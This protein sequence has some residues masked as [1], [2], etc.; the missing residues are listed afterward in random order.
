MRIALIQTQHNKLYNF[1][2][3]NQRLMYTE[4]KKLQ[5][6][7]IEQ[8]LTL[9]ETAIN[10]GCDLIVTTEAINYAGQPH[11]LIKDRN[12]CGKDTEEFD[13]YKQYSLLIPTVEDK[14]VL[15]IAD[16]ARKGKCYIVAG[17]YLKRVNEGGEYLT[18]SAVIFNPQGVIED[19]YDKIHL[20][21][22][23]ND[24]LKS[25]E[26]YVSFNTE[27]GKIGVLICFDA[28][29]PEAYRELA[30]RNCDLV[31]CSTW[32]WEQIY[33]HARAYE[34]GIYVASAMAVPYWGA[35]DGLRTPSEIIAPAGSVI[36]RA[37][38]DKSD[39]I[40]SDV[41]IRDCKSN[42]SQRLGWR[43]PCTYQLIN[44]ED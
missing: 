33:G 39:I 8:A 28:Q 15:R 5:T 40:I 44:K 37:V 19:I 21:G 23:E 29:F 20:A 41:P 35:I 1:L 6:E 17:L 16:L 4:S 14:V 30:L 9:M 7:M 32:G 13:R 38:N 25:G 31:V 34:N 43:H 11:Q 26:R 18:N 22:S 10:K 42:R 12:S 27:Y 3:P 2:E 24:Y 36:T